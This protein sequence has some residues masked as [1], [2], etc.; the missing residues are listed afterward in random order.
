MCIHGFVFFRVLSL[1][2]LCHRS[3]KYIHARNASYWLQF[4]SQY[5]SPY[6]NLIREAYFF[7]FSGCTF[8]LFNNF[9]FLVCISLTGDVLYFN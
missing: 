1:T 4:I 5:Q 2:T 9:F 8:Q 3:S 6:Q 7:V